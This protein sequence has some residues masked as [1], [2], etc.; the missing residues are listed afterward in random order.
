MCSA[1]KLLGVL[2]GRYVGKPIALKPTAETSE[3]CRPYLQDQGIIIDVL[4]TDLGRV[5]PDYGD[6]AFMV[7]KPD[8]SRLVIHRLND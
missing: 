3:V 8:G 1:E 4:P 7:L 5:S 2:R 6:F